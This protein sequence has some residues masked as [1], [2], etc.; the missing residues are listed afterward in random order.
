MRGEDLARYTRP[1][2]LKEFQHNLSMAQQYAER[3]FD[4]DPTFV[5]SSDLILTNAVVVG[6]LVIISSMM[7][8]VFAPNFHFPIYVSHL[9]T[10]QIL[11]VAVLVEAIAFAAAMLLQVRGLRIER[12][13]ALLA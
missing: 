5:I 4:L 9:E 2:A 10:G 12:R 1:T 7:L 13:D 3:A 6:M 11:H 8:K